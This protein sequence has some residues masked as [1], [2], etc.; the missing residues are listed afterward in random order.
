MR[1]LPTDT[2]GFLRTPYAAL[3][4]GELSREPDRAKG[5]GRI[6]D[7]DRDAAHFVDIDEAGK[8]LGGPSFRPLPATRADYETALRAAGLDSWKTGYLQYSIIDRAQQL[9][10]YF[11]YWR[12]LKAAE[13]NPKWR[14]NRRW[15]AADRRRREALILST[16]GELSHFVGDGSQ[17]LHVSIHYNGWGDYPNPEGF[18][19]ARLHGPFE[20]DLVLANVSYPMV[21]AAMTRPTLCNCPPEQRTLGYL[22]ATLA[23]VIPVYRLE[24]AGG[25]RNGDPRGTAFAALQLGIGA[26]ELRDVITEAWRASADV[27][28]GWRPIAVADVVAGKVDP[29]P[30]LYGID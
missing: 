18:S 20:G 12:V 27:K 22:E 28:V 11:G 2:P 29:Y 5:S 26:S 19:N 6:H 23:Q 10:L 15:F 21:T 4:V 24:K 25:L 14:A 8:L 17:P 9:T 1:A 30:N 13:A 3:E 7:H 16:I